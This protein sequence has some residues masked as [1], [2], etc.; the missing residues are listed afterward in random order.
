MEANPKKLPKSVSARDD[1]V[2]EALRE[3]LRKRKVQAQT[4][5]SL[6]ESGDSR[7]SLES[8]SERRSRTVQNNSLKDKK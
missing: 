5:D 7:L 1:R 6:R 2:A 4:R 8:A 3:N